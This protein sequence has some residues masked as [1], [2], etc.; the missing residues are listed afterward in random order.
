MRASLGLIAV[1]LISAPAQAATVLAGQGA[2]TCAFYAEQVRQYPIDMHAAYF[3]WTQGF[4]SGMNMGL[5]STGDDRDLAG[6]GIADQQREID[7]FCDRHPLVSFTDAVVNIFKA[8]PKKPQ[9]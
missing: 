2:A 4:M 9:N 6:I 3:A 5:I 1:L 7:A 8:L